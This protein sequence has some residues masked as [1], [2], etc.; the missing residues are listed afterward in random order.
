M[1]ECPLCMAMKK[2]GQ[3]KEVDLDDEIGMK[4]SLLDELLGELDVATAS[5]FKKPKAMSIEVISAK[6]KKKEEE[7]EEF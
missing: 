4:D 2:K 5:K 3:A 6:P 1:M 7:E